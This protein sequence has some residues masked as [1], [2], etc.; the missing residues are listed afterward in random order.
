MGDRSPPRRREDRGEPQR[1]EDVDPPPSNRLFV[2]RGKLTLLS[3]LQ[4]A[5][6]CTTKKSHV[7]QF[8][9]QVRLVKKQ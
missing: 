6:L 5:S 2:V 1:G 8:S 4:H 7:A 3:C 9:S